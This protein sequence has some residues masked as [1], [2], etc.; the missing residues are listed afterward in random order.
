MQAIQLKCA[1]SIGKHPGK[2]LR[3]ARLARYSSV[4]L[5]PIVVQRASTPEH[6]EIV[7]GLRAAGF[8]RVTTEKAQNASWIDEA[9]R[10][11]G[12]FSLIGYGGDHVP[13]ATLRIHDGRTAPLE[14]GKFV[15]IDALLQ[16]ADKPVAQFSR[17]SVA[18][19]P[20]ATAAMFG[21]FK[22]AWRWCLAEE[23]ATIVIAT[24]PWSRLIYDF[25]LF[26]PLG[27]E[28]EFRHAFAGGA[29]HVVMKSSVPTVEAHWRAAHHPLWNQICNI[30]HPNLYI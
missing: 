14:L 2:T 12:V 3:Q 22:A 24:P 27:P 13:V 15:P 16:P 28:G 20:N 30:R 17:L 5:G 25:L 1:P 21:L 10:A 7:A 18:K 26:E 11:P 29:P 23:I 8:G 6:F 9:D 19:S 4:D